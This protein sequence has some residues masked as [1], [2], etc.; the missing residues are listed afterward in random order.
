METRKK[1]SKPEVIRVE[2]DSTIS[3]MFY[4]PPNNPMMMPIMADASKGTDT[5]FTSPFD[6]K[7]FS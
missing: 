2:L 7:P 1:Y 3:L 4:S 5:P 6:D